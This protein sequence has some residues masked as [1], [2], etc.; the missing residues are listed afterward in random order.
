VPA[1]E[2]PFHNGYGKK[3]RTI[4]YLSLGGCGE[5]EYIVTEE[6]AADKIVIPQLV[7]LY[8]HN[9][10]KLR[11]FCQGKHISE[12]PSLK[13]FTIEDCKAVEVILGDAN[14]RKLEGSI[15][16]WQPLLLV[17]KVCTHSS[18]FAYLVC[19]PDDLS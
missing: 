14:C 6:E 15:L 2:K 17:E 19:Y 3:S 18:L 10:P 11:S 8:L 16:I 5:M 13:E 1:S 12:W 9:M 4:Q 7:T